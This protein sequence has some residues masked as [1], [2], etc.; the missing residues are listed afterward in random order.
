MTRPE[1]SQ[2]ILRSDDR[3]KKM[4]YAIH[5]AFQELFEMFSYI[6]EKISTF[7]KPQVKDFTDTA[8]RLR[9]ALSLLD[10]QPET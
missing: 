5:Y 7:N 1:F 2:E 4:K 8:T 9:N 6:Q 3:L 10:K